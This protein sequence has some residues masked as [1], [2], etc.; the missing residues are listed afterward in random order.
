MGH[1]KCEKCRKDGI[2]DCCCDCSSG[3]ERNDP[4]KIV[5]DELDRPCINIVNFSDASDFA[6]RPNHNK[7][8]AMAVLKQRH[9]IQMVCEPRIFFA[10]SSNELLAHMEQF[11]NDAD[12]GIFGNREPLSAEGKRDYFL[13]YISNGCHWANPVCNH[14]CNEFS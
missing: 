12:T 7:V 3:H 4:I 5:I 2:E 6:A 11:K 10:G 9:C 1:S 8:G 13:N 14:G